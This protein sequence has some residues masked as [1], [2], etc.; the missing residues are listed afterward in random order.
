MFKLPGKPSLR[1]DIHELADYAELLAWANKSVSAREIL[2]ILGR[3]AE[4]D[5]NEGCEDDENRSADAFE[6]VSTEF[7]SRLRA[8]SGR[9]P[10]TLDKTGNVLSYSPG[11][12][13]NAAW[14][15]G[16]LLLS[17]RLNMKDSRIHAGIDGT[18]ILEEVA[19]TSL[20]QYLGPRRAKAMMFGTAA[21]SSDFP[22]RVTKLCN[23]LG[24]GFQFRNTFSSPS[25][26]KD[27]KLDTVAWIPFSDE[28]C[29]KIIVFGQCKTGTAWT[30][31]LCQLR[32]DN[33][34]KKWIHTPFALD[35]LRAYCISE[36]GNRNTWSGNAIEGGL[37]F[38]RCRLMD[39]CERIEKPLLKRMAKWSKAALKVAKAAL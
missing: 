38:D 17:T 37:L 11:H 34:V 28:K 36:S 25:T 24:E 14:L 39:C 12:D 33:F 30:E 21:G 13:Q 16:Y 7:D 6:E 27:D 31:Q 1:A 19:T 8:C 20:Q 9:Y 35:P 26:A 2:A 3:E 23:L 10:F 32:P 4:N 5:G 18:T 29:S 22:Q 15:Y